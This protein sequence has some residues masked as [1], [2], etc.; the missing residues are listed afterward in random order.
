M[1]G[2]QA[3]SPAAAP[4][5]QSALG[6]C[7]DWGDAAADTAAQARIL[8]VQGEKRQISGLCPGGYQHSLHVSSTTAYFLKSFWQ[9]KEEALLNQ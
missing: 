3:E 9:A 8:V 4:H 5:K 6:R 2:E 1:E 7:T